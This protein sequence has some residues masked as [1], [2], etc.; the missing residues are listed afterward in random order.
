MGRQAGQ[1]AKASI[2]SRCLPG[3]S[4][5]RAGGIQVVVRA[6]SERV[7]LGVPSFLSGWDCVEHIVSIRTAHLHPLL[8][9]PC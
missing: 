5:I 3:L 1:V 4:F 9:W 2:Y 8:P 7:R 6:T